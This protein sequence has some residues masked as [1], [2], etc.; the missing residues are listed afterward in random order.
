MLGVLSAIGAALRRSARGRP[1][2]EPVFFL[3]I[4]AG[5]VLGPG[6]GFVLGSHDPVRLGAGHRRRRPVAAV[7]DVRRR[8]GRLRRRA[9]CRRRRGRR[10][11]VMLAG[12]G[13]VAGAGL[14]P[15][16]EPVVLAVR[17]RR[18]HRDLVRAR[19]AARR[20]PAR[21]SA[22]HLATSMGWDIPRR[23]TNVVLVLLPGPTVL[24]GAAPGRPPG[25][26]RARDG[27]PRDG[28]TT[29]PEN[30]A[31]SD[32]PAISGRCDHQRLALP[33]HLPPGEVRTW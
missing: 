27:H 19:C 11:I 18:R 25:G 33:P 22:L 23:I 30:R 14:R 4:L 32:K 5:R 29:S 12:Y 9:A 31:P 28:P 2:F 20:E 13:V 21:A 15:A 7:P 16:D 10:E 1:A 17:H 26:L 24:G 8:V 6:F 3:L